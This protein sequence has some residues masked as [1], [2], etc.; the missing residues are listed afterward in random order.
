MSKKKKTKKKSNT[1]ILLGFAGVALIL[2][3]GYFATQSQGT[4]HSIHSATSSTEI[5]L[6][7]SYAEMTAGLDLIETR[8][9]VPAKYFRGST[10]QTYQ[11]AAEIPQV[12]D[13]L[14]C[15]C[16]CKEN[17]RFKHKNLLTCYTD[18]HASKC[19][20]CLK[21]GVMAHKMTKDGKSP[22]KIREAIDSY[23]AKKKSRRS[24]F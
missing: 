21:E 14:Y 13:Q 16:M 5:P 22:N 23:Y 24:F 4:G 3:I 9:V 15:H 7:S 2:T 18:E 19:A 11:W 17:P 8:T 12:F 6:G 1:G 10:A 20:I